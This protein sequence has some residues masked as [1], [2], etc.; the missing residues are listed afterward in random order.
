MNAKRLEAFRLLGVRV[1]AAGIVGKVI[2]I[3]DEGG[4]KISNEN[5]DNEYSY[6]VQLKEVTFVYLP[7]LPS[8]NGKEQVVWH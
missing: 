1:E 2:A 7:Y 8:D 4:I 5:E 6:W 3:S